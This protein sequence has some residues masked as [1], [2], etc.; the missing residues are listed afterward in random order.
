MPRVDLSPEFAA[1]IFDAPEGK[2]VGPLLDPL[3]FTLVKVEKKDLG[4][5]PSL[6]SVRPMIEE[7]VR[8]EKNSAQYM[9]W[10]ESRRKRAMIDIK[11]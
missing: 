4:P 10:I 7:R 3:G 2:L 11:I 9:R 5:A 6:A 8:S 1:I